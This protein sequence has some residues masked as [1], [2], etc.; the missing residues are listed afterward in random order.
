MGQ[1]PDGVERLASRRRQTTADDERDRFEEVSPGMSL[2]EHRQHSVVERLD[3]A[4]HEQ[5]TGS[6]QRRQELTMLEQMLDLDDD[7]VGQLR[8]GGVKSL[9]DPDRM[10]RPVEEVG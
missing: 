1:A 7:V 3:R 6:G 2:L 9:D 8:K 5:A 10:R 4:R